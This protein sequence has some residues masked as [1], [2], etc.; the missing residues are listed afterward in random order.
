MEA[1]KELDLS[2][3]SPYVGKEE[4]ENKNYWWLNAKPSIWSFSD[5]AVGEVVNYVSAMNYGLERLKEF[6]DI[7]I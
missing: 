6:R 4:S 3:F 1:L 5:L 7:G 2:G